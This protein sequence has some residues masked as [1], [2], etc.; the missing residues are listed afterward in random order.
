[1]HIITHNITQPSLL[2][3]Y[4]YYYYYYFKFEPF[5]LEKQQ[6]ISSQCYYHY[7]VQPELPEHFPGLV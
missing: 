4:Y 1:M 7:K 3:Y 6:P 5:T 2:N